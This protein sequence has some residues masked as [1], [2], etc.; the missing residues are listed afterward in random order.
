M[1]ENIYKWYD[2]NFQYPKYINSS[3]DS[4]SKN[5]TMKKNGQIWIDIFQRKHAVGQQAYKKCSKSVLIREMHIKSTMKYHFT[6]VRMTTL[7]K[8]ANNECWLG[9]GE[10][11]SLGHCWQECKL[12]EPLWKPLKRPQK[13]KNRTTLWLSS[14]IPGYISREKWKH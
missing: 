1:I 2:H 6:P 13:M 4:V 12:V 8:S 7:K 14:A 3:Y 9:C 5:S 11:G 10:K